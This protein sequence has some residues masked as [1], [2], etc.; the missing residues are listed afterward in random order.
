VGGSQFRDL[1]VGGN[2]YFGGKPQPSEPANRSSVSNKPERKPNLVILGI[3]NNSIPEEERI[4]WN[5]DIPISLMALL[6]E[7]QPSRTGE[8]FYRYG[9]FRMR[10]PEI[11]PRSKFTGDSGACIWA[12]TYRV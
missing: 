9:T 5:S 6:I 10:E 8:V 3:R 1:K 11:F 7:N 4:L 2:A 12:R